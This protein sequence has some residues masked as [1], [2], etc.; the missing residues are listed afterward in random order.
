[1]PENCEV[2]L[3]G[4]YDSWTPYTGANIGIYTEYGWGQTVFSGIEFLYHLSNDYVDHFVKKGNR[5]RK[6]ITA[7]KKQLGDKFNKLCH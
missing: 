4:G 1:M 5:F 7:P 6:Q 2:H 3:N